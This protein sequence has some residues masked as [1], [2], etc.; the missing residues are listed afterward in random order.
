[1]NSPSYKEF[2]SVCRRIIAKNESKDFS[3]VPTNNS[4]TL[5]EL[6]SDIKEAKIQAFNIKKKML[7]SLDK[8][9]LQFEQIFQENGGVLFWAAEYEEALNALKEI[10]EKNQLNTVHLERD[11]L[12]EE[13]EL[14]SFLRHEEIKIKPNREVL[15]FQANQLLVENGSIVV[16]T[17]NK[18]FYDNL[19][20]SKIKICF[21]PIHSL[22]SS[23][24]DLDLFLNLYSIYN[25]GQKLE[26]YSVVLTPNKKEQ[27]ELFYLILLDNN[28]TS[29]LESKEHYAA[30]A[31]IHCNACRNVCPVYKT[32]GAEPY[33]SVF[34]GP[35]AKVVSPFLDNVETTK[36]LSFTSTLCGACAEICPLNIPLQD[37][38]I[39]NR[40]IIRAENYVDYKERAKIK[41][42]SKFLTNRKKMNAKSWR[43]NLVFKWFLDK[44]I[45]WNRHV[46][47]FEKQSFNK[48]QISPKKKKSHTKSSL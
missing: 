37:L 38:I 34:A 10:L 2:N 11:F 8:N 36:H 4:A 28:R 7:S 5:N 22:L 30:L 17:H 33:N 9:C 25:S 23:T 31:C 16:S 44:E 3:F 26:T 15:V 35:L 21:V 43:K 19:I 18:E 24:D 46:P 14:E 47:S 40:Q 27:E 32:I 29:L 41:R 20:S 6:F 39:K 12:F 48:R 1:M 13:I 42:L 45:R